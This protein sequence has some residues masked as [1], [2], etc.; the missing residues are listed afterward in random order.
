MASTISLEYLE[1]LYNAKNGIPALDDTGKLPDTLLPASAFGAYLGDFQTYG[2]LSATSVLVANFAPPVSIATQTTG[3][4][5]GY[6]EYTVA[7]VTITENFAHSADV[8]IRPGKQLSL[9]LGEYGKGKL[10]NYMYF[11]PIAKTDIT[12]SSDPAFVISDVNTVNIASV[13][14]LSYNHRV[15]EF[16]IMRKSAAG[17]EITLKNLRANRRRFPY[18]ESC[19]CSRWCREWSACR[20]GCCPTA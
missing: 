11:A 4:Q 5:I 3:I 20:P 1:S 13:S 14:S 15:V 9:A 12:T 8:A 16:T 6:Q 2:E 10:T 18:R 17:A 19:L 7:D